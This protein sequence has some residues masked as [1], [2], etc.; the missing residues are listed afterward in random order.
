MFLL[1]LKITIAEMGEERLASRMAA[2]EGGLGMQVDNVRPEWQK[3]FALREGTGVV[4]TGVSQDSPADDAGLKA[5][6]VIKEVNRKS[7]K[8]VND[9]QEYMGKIKSGP[10]V[11]LLIKRGGRTFYV[12]IKI[13]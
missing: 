13:S 8:D 9:Y 1:D 12:S 7:V 2:P 3:K 10:P 4:V 5:G 6:D 11:L